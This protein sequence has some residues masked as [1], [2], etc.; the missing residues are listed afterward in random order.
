[1]D[2]IFSIEKFN[3]IKDKNNYYYFRALNLGD[4]T[5]LDNNIIT[6]KDGKIEKIRTDR[7]RYLGIPKYKEDSKLSLEEIIDHIKENHRLDTNCISV[8][9]NSNVALMYG[10]K[11]YKDKY[12]MIKSPQTNPNKIINATLYLLKEINKKINEYLNKKQVSKELKDKILKIDNAK[13]KEEL[14]Q[15]CNIKTESTNKI[16]YKDLSEKQEL[17]KNKII[18]K[19]II[20]DNNL[21]EKISNE[22]L[23]NTINNAYASLEFIHYKA[24]TKEE[25]IEI[26]PEIMDVFS[27]IQQLPPNIN[28][29]TDLITET[30]K[31]LKKDY[32][33]TS[34]SYS[35]YHIKENNISKELKE[36]YY[37]F[38]YLT[39]SKLRVINAI[40][41]IKIITNNNPKY[42][43]I[44]SYLNKNV[45]AI[46]PEII[47]NINTKKDKLN[48]Y[49]NHLNY[50]EKVA[51]IEKTEEEFNKYKHKLK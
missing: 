4:N 26:T 35:N 48:K 12:I 39:K 3:I 16:N 49:L 36:V 30:L 47:N 37:N 8:T 2:N 13:T 7:E 43:T 28:Y 38:F 32:Y 22:D 6:A 10:R 20:I 51:I 14:E 27:L 11:Y 24:I 42:K 5:D 50:S 17:Q 21:V 19:L 18:T 29:K 9:T 46:E 15:I 31:Y 1:M 34:F 23:I 45:F 25:I 41:N 40:N 44:I 33:L